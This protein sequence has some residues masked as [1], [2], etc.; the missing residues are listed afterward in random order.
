L[1]FW[2]LFLDLVGLFSGELFARIICL[3]MNIVIDVTFSLKKCS[4][5][6]VV[7]VCKL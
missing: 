1:N 6:K 5:V 3:F 7:Y 2:Y 4:I